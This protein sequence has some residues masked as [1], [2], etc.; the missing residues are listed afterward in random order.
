VQLINNILQTNFEV[1]EIQNTP[2]ILL[3]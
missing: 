2:Q 1:F 3:V